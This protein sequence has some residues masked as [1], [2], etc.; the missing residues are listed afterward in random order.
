MRTRSNTEP[1]I[2]GGTDV[3]TN[4]H[5]WLVRV[6]RKTCG[7]TII[8]WNHVVTSAVCCS[9]TEIDI[10]IGYGTSEVSFHFII[11]K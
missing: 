4:S 10:V 7:G 9:F 5:P 1:R 2:I 8:G 6:A 3:E 11:S